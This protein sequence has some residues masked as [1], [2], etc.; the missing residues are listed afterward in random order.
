MSKTVEALQGAIDLL[1]TLYESPSLATTNAL[2]LIDKELPRLREA[3]NEELNN[4][5]TYNHPQEIIT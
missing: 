5:H 1:S 3:L 2:V 4:P